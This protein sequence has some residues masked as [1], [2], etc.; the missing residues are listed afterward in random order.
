MERILTIDSQKEF[1]IPQEIKENLHL[2]PND[3]L[4]VSSGD[5]FIIIRKIRKPSLDE[6]FR[7]LSEKVRRK[8]K[9]EGIT[10]KD[11]DKAIKW[12]RRR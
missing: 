4:L 12:A 8:F 3:N 10:P 6:R 5:D 1:E 11:V 7:S 9:N 2:K